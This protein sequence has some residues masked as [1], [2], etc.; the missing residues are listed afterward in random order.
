MLGGTVFLSKAVA[1]E[2]VRRGHDVTCACRGESGAL[3]DGV[4]H[5]V[6]DRDRP[7]PAELTDPAETAYDAVVDVA[8]HPSRVRSAVAALTDAHWVFVSTIS[9]YSDNAV[10]GGGPAVSY[11]HLTLPT[12]R[13][14]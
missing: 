7:A 3:P 1:E 10:P 11:T 13:E 5:V 2:A 6:W 12:N 4:T 14:V 9:V 8:R